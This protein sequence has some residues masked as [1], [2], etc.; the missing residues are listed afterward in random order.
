MKN[1]FY[2]LMILALSQG[3]LAGAV[4][5]HNDLALTIDDI[6]AVFSGDKSSVGGTKV[7]LVD[8]KEAMDNFCTKVLGMEASKYSAQWAKKSFRDGVPSPKAKNSDAEVNDFVKSTP[9][10]VGYVAG[11]PGAGVKSVSSF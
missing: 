4:I 9:G 10:A 7:V 11:S 2:S 1:L 5:A 8:N 6:K 3:T